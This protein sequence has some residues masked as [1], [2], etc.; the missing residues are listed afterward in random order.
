[1]N[2]VPNLFIEV[3]SPPDFVRVEYSIERHR[4]LEKKQIQKMNKLKSRLNKIKKKK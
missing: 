4:D 2:R 3:K 1:M